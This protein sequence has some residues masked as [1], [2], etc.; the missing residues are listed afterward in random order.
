MDPKKLGA[1]LIPSQ[2]QFELNNSEGWY[3]WHLIICLGRVTEQYY[4]LDFAGAFRRSELVQL[5][6]Q[7][8][9][10]SEEGIRLNLHSSKTDQEGVGREI[11]IPY[12]SYVDTCP[13][14]ILRAWVEQAKIDEGPLCKA[15][16]ISDSALCDK[17][18]NQDYERII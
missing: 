13:V 18:V 17:T 1:P 7:D 9:L 3:Q 8:I 11:G 16:K 15:G 4:S 12:G 14:R 5:V 10:F 6:R 2:H